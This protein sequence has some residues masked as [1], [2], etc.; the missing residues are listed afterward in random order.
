[1]VAVPAAEI[2]DGPAWGEA[3]GAEHGARALLALAPV[4]QE[5]AA[6][7]PVHGTRDAPAHV[8][9]QGRAGVRGRLEVDVR[10]LQE[11][12]RGGLSGSST[13]A[14]TAEAGTDGCAGHEGESVESP[15]VHGPRA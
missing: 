8:L 11:Y 7:A 15:V 12:L 5:P 4:A 2:G 10:C 1:M 6:G 9:G 3:E 14:L 13:A